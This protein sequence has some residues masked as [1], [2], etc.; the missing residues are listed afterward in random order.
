MRAAP[1]PLPRHGEHI[2]PDGLGIGEVVDSEGEKDSDAAGECVRDPA[3][4]GR[5]AIELDLKRDL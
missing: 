2:G 4:D 3:L 1:V 5:F